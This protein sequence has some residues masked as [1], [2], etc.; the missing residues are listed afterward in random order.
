M[1]ASGSS[2]H[3]AHKFSELIAFICIAKTSEHMNIYS[4]T[5]TFRNF[6]ESNYKFS[7][8]IHTDLEC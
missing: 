8:S 3:L 7:Y 2:G 6:L 1:S 5:V 4:H